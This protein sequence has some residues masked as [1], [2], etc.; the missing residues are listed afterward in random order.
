MTI[1]NI[2]FSQNGYL[3][4]HDCLEEE[5]LIQLRQAV[6]RSVYSNL[7]AVFDPALSEFIESEINI[8]IATALLGERNFLFHHMNAACHGVDT[9][10]LAWHH[11]YEDYT[12]QGKKHGMIHIF[13]YLNGLDNSIGELVLIPGSHRWHGSRYHLS[14]KS[15]DSFPDAI[16]IGQLKPGSVIVIHSALVHGRRALPP[17]AVSSIRYFVDC[18]YCQ[19]GGKWAPFREA[20]NWKRT[21]DIVSGMSKTRNG[22][23]FAHLYDPSRF[24][25]SA[26]DKLIDCLNVRAAVNFTAGLIRGK[27]RKSLF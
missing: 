25:V 16:A 19:Y 24:Y 7:P 12:D 9:P 8:R 3:V 17:N 27:K 11:D 14:D 2:S 15:F 6:D 1:D 4:L 23:K 26:K 13:H 5:A 22:D 21:L 20:G 10:S 18:S